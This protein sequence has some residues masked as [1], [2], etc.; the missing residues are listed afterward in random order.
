MKLYFTSVNESD[1]PTSSE[2]AKASFPSAV[3]D[4]YNL[5]FS[6][7]EMS[8]NLSDTDDESEWPSRVSHV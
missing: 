5:D 6:E 4:K 8:D 2:I 7:D 1:L 3:S